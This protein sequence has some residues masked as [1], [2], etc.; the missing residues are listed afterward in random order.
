MATLLMKNG[1]RIIFEKPQEM[2]D[3][4]KMLI[5]NEVKEI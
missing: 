1:A 4:A 2:I 3:Y 5:E